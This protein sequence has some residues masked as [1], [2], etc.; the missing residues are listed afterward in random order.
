MPEKYVVAVYDYRSKQEYI[1]KSNRVKQIVGASEIIKNSYEKI[2]AECS[3]IV[4]DMT[5]DFSLEEFKNSAS[6]GT[7][8][9]EGGGNIVIL[10]KSKEAC[11][12]FNRHFSKWLRCNARGLSPVCGMVET[13]Y[14]ELEKKTFREITRAIFADLDEYKRLAPPIFYHNILPFTQIDRGT[15]QPIAFKDRGKKVS[16]SKESMQKLEAFNN[17]NQEIKTD[18][19][20]NVSEYAQV[21]D[22]LV[23][24]KGEESLIAIIYIDG[25][26][27]GQRV[28]DWISE[29][30]LFEDGVNMQR[31]FTAE[32]NE[33]FVEKPLKAIAETVGTVNEK[34]KSVLEMRQIIGGGDEITIVCNARKALKLL[35]VYF[36]S[37]HSSEWKFSACAGVVICHSGA[38]FSEMYS[39][40]EAC[41]ESGKKRIKRLLKEGKEECSNNSYIDA[42][43]CRGAI[44]ADLEILRDKQ[45][46]ELTNMPYCVKGKDEEHS[47]EEFERIGEMLQK[48]KRTNVKALRDAA[49]RSETDFQLELYRIQSNGKGNPDL[50]KADIP[51]L[52]DV[53][54]FYEIWFEEV[55]KDA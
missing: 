1:Y 17:M 40:A 6:K 34:G 32:I 23:E 42:Y 38:P 20:D 19:E 43:F 37:L 28:K 4:F 25:N 35:K 3:E 8:L 10:F 29:D 47:Y 13:A 12:D 16:L 24:E 54:D 33:A 9:Y 30:M 52:C 41:C 36:E 21:F 2:L 55:D 18:R 11:I 26:G 50:S 15:S 45:R 39:V 44:T 7:V 49:F 22:S 53:S 27:L 5:T 51:I 14:G 31:I 46:K 48:I